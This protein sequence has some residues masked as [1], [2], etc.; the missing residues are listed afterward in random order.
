[1]PTKMARSDELYPGCVTSHTQINPAPGTHNEGSE[2][3]LRCF[4][5]EEDKTSWCTKRSIHI[6]ILILNSNDSS[7]HTTNRCQTA[8]HKHNQA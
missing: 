3:M 8:P 1:M 7:E 4:K 6:W 2:A 5:E